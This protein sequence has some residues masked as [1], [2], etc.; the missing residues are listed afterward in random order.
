M[1]Q[2]SEPIYLD[3]NASAPLLPEVKSAMISMM[4]FCGNSASVHTH[5][6]KIRSYVDVARR[7][8][9]ADVDAKGARLIFTGSA[10]EANNMVLKGIVAKS[11]VISA[12]E[13]ASLFQ[14][15]EDVHHIP[16]DENGIVKLSAL[17]QILRTL[18]PPALVSVML[19]NNETGVIQPVEEVVR[20]AHSYSAIVH[21]D[22]V[23]ALGKVPVSFHGLGVDAMTLGAHKFGGPPGVGALIIH[24]GLNFK[25]LITGGGHEQGFRAGTQNVMLIEGF[26]I[27]LHEATQN[28]EKY[29]QLGILRDRLEGEILKICPEAKIYGRGAKRVPNTTVI[30][31]PHVSSEVQLM[32]FDLAGISI[33]IGSACSSGKV[34][35]SHVLSAMGVQNL[36]QNGAIRVSLGW[37]TKPQ[38]IEVF[39][40][41]WKHIYQGNL[42]RLAVC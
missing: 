39:V 22:V 8:V 13:H 31:M 41:E 5:G 1:N 2:K 32:A 16:V 21:T 27:A 23:Q 20:I 14:I 33:S 7:E 10:T 17:E 3:Y 24:D 42:Q 38:D 15:S 4:D 40:S 28:F 34:K 12:I 11:F 29:Q 25:P 30:A 9:L 18:E 36:H 26:R 35:P 37:N 19:V 6:R